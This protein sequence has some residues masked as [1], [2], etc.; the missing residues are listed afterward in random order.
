MKG[1]PV[2]G[3]EALSVG[4]RQTPLPEGTLTFLL[5][6]L[7]GSTRAWESDPRLM[8]EVMTRHDRIL[9]EVVRRHHGAPVEAGREGDSVLAVFQRALDAGACALDLQNAFGSEPWPAGISV[10]L[11]TAL[12]TGEAVLR[13]GHYYGQPLNRCARLLGAANGGQVLV[14]RATEQLLVDQLPSGTALLDLGHHRLKDLS[15]P[16]HVFQ[17]IDA[18]RPTE[19]PRI[20]SLLSGLTKPLAKK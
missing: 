1:E 13:D 12:H 9:A 15:R 4:D 16:E 19:F 11:R 8:H 7:V 17:L 2:S 18:G 5:T 3:E 10:R 6:D 20:Q 14:T